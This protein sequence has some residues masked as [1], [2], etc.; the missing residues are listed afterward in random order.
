[1]RRR[2]KDFHARHA[3][4]GAHD[5][6][7]SMA[8]FV[9]SEKPVFP[10][11]YLARKNGLLAVGGD[12]TPERLVVAYRSGIF[13]WYGEGEPIL[14]WSPDPRLV[15]FPDKLHVSKRLKRVLKKRAFRVTA[16]TAFGRVITECARIRMEKGKE[17]WIDSRMIDAYCRLHEYGIAHSVESWQGETLSGGLYGVALGR[18]FFGE[19]MFSRTSDASKTALV[20]LVGHLLERSFTMIDCQTTTLHLMRMGATHIPRSLF[21]ELLEK[22]MNGP[23]EEKTWKMDADRVL[24]R[25]LN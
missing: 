6:I 3:F 12:L 10:P 13:P 25:V 14:W 9:L 21:L 8:V 20:H 18:C 22:S 16:D 11:P 1:V 17:T 19:S 2:E 23:P 5:A 7:G 4:D 15:L 24:K